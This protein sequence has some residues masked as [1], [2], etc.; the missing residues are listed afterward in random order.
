MDGVRY[1]PPAPTWSLVEPPPAVEI[2]ADVL[3]LAVAALE[4]PVEAASTKNER[5]RLRRRQLGVAHACAR[6]I[7]WTAMEWFW[8]EGGLE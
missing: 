1:R 7:D 3:G 4:R 6:A 2:A 8:I 5:D